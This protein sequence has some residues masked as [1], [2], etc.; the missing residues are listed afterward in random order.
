MVRSKGTRPQEKFRYF[1]LNNKLHKVLKS[2]RV[3]NTLIA[4]SYEDKKRVLYVFSDVKK[5][6]Q[7]AYSLAEVCKMLNKHRVTIQDY[8]L[9]GK[10]R[11][12]QRIYPIG[13]AEN[14][15]WS[16]YMFSEDDIVELYDYIISAGREIEKLPTK[17]ELKAL[18]K[19]NVILYT[20]TSEGQFVPVW[21]AND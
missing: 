15:K 13:N 18:I 4:W 19:H 6:K 17:S 14:F 3:K 10:V 21:K 1:Y 8:I 2:S 7:N 12:P 20:K 16:Q 5:Y 9:E 11:A